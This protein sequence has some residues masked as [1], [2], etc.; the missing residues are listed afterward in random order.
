[1][2]RHSAKSARLPRKLLRGAKLLDDMTGEEIYQRDSNVIS[3]NGRYYHRS[4]FDYMTTEQEILMHQNM[5]N[6]RSSNGVYR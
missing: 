3:R 2:A 1:M 6:R 4:N 5:L